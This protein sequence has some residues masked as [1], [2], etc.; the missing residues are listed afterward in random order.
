MFKTFPE[1]SKLTLDDKEEY[2]S[3]I[4]D[5]PPASSFSFADLMTWWNTLGHGSVACLNG[6]LIIS[7]WLPGEEEGTGLSI[8]GTHDID[9]SLCTV[10]DHL[11]S[12]GEKPQLINVPEFVIH[13][14]RYPEMFS[15][16]PHRRYDEYVLKVTDFYPL[17]NMSS[18]WRI[19]VKRKLAS[20][21][22]HNIKVDILD[23]S[24]EENMYLLT[25]VLKNWR[26]QNVNNFGK[27]EE[28]AVDLS[29]RGAII[30]GIEAVCLW[31]DEILYGFCLI[32]RDKTGKRATLHCVK[33]THM[34]A[35]GY[36][37]LLHLFAK[38]FYEQGVEVVNMG[39]D[40]GLL[41]VRMLLLTLGPVEFNRKYYVEPVRASH[42]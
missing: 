22:Q 12:N 10:F 13:S 39:S 2:E 30:L 1:F 16:S 41:R 31:V 17:E 32:T 9:Q 20:L 34:K 37:G 40:N 11:L 14:I 18:I 7:Y 8:V 24:R 42:A 19:K 33:A 29:L 27:F 6:N 4:K 23:L 5:F 26:Q 28:N 25:H 35:M 38:W 21:K 36:E 3:Y 15:V